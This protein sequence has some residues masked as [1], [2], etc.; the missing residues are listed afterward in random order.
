MEF[1]KCFWINEKN[2]KKIIFIIGNELTNTIE[3]KEILFCVHKHE[4]DFQNPNWQKNAYKWTH[5]S[6]ATT[7][8]PK[9]MFQKIACHNAT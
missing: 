9:Q 6:K 5:P 3:T 7:T 8:N 1:K 2:E 4:V